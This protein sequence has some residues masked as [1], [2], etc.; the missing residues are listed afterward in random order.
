MRIIRDRRRTLHLTHSFQKEGLDQH[1]YAWTRDDSVLKNVRHLT[2]DGTYTMKQIFRN[3][4][5]SWVQDLD[6]ICKLIDRI[7]N[8]KSLTWNIGPM[9]RTIIEAL[10]QRHPTAILRIFNYWRKDQTIDHLTED[11]LMVSNFKNLTDFRAVTRRHVDGDDYS[12]DVF[13]HMIANSKSLQYAGIID[14]NRSV[15]SNKLLALE[16][17]GDTDT[18]ES[19]RC[20]S[21]KTLTLDSTQLELSK[22]TLE[23][24]D[25]FI[26]IANLE[27]LKFVRGQP[28]LN[29][30][31]NAVS[32]LPSI[33]HVSL[34]F[35]AVIDRPSGSNR[36]AL[37]AAAN[38]YLLSCPPLQS[39]SIWNALPHVGL[40]KLVDHHSTTIQALQ[41]H[42]REFG[43]YITRSLVP[44]GIV[45]HLRET[46]LKLKD[47]TI[48]INRGSGSQHED[49]D[50][51]EDTVV[52]TALQSLVLERNTTVLSTL[53]ELALFGPRLSRLQVYVESFDLDVL[54]DDYEDDSGFSMGDPDTD[55]SDSVIPVSSQHTS[56]QSHPRSSAP[57]VRNT[58]TDAQPNKPVNP[59]MLMQRYAED[60]WKR[61]FGS[62][63]FGERLLDVKFGEWEAK[64]GYGLG[65]DSRRFFEVRPH[66]RDDRIGDCSTRMK[67]PQQH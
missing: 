39:L 62:Q 30:F 9:P 15:L 25:R 34:N 61:V 57:P 16:A 24:F 10:G 47:L 46:C 65:S 31:Q 32:M 55:T 3:H 58:R 14:S 21:L 22:T 19:K 50:G 12:L 5:G 54:F 44:L 33:K 35:Q 41:I 20:E 43:F 63:Q 60:I 23:D 36:N 59:E 48:D 26:N 38:E 66:E 29:Y 4:Y 27:T 11:E 6:P 18:N 17:D 45:T 49:D 8:L 42:Q 64:A 51:V 52:R 13:K 2:I 53:N 7:S 1:E 67:K 28:E 40:Q 56:D 37:L